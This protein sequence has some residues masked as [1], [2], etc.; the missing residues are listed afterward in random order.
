MKDVVRYVG[1]FRCSFNSGSPLATLSPFVRQLMALVEQP[2]A[3]GRNVQLLLQLTKQQ[4]ALI[5]KR[6]GLGYAK[7]VTHQ[8]LDVLDGH[9]FRDAYSPYSPFHRANPF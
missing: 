4:R 2:L 1:C 3:D 5:K 9:L 7:H 6:E 8:K